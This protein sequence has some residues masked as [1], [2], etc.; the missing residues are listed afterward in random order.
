MELSIGE[1]WKNK[2]KNEF[3]ASPRRALKTRQCLFFSACRDL[4]ALRWRAIKI[5]S[6]LCCAKINLPIVCMKT[7]R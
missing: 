6:K 4:K 7:V 1:L 2:L 5:Q 3:E